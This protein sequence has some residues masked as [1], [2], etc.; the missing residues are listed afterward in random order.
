MS[1]ADVRKRRGDSESA[2][3]AQERARNRVLAAARDFLDA[4]LGELKQVLAVEGLTPA[5][6]MTTLEDPKRYEKLA[7]V[8]IGSKSRIY[9]WMNRLAL[10]MNFLGT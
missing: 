9:C 2:G 4:I 1:S 3:E 6:G 5:H 10:E 8:A 7:F